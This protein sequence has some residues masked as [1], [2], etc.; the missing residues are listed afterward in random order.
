MV[1]QGQ[2]GAGEGEITGR[3]RGENGYERE[4]DF[5]TDFKSQIHIKEDKNDNR[6][7]INRIKRIGL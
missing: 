5:K 7:M 6:R 1:D 4:A 2:K 3:R